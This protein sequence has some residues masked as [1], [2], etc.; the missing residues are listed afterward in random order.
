MYL[1]DANLAVEILRERLHPPE[2]RRIGRERLGREHC[3][4]LLCLRCRYMRGA[5]GSE[6]SYNLLPA[7]PP[8][9]EDQE[10]VAI[11]LLPQQV[12]NRRDVLARVR[13]VG[14]GTV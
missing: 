6:A 13:P 9:L 10:G 11:E 4:S 5:R 1:R 3:L 12:I 8:Q 7:A 14:A 2:R